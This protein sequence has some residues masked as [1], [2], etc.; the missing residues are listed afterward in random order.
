MFYTYIEVDGRMDGTFTVWR[1]CKDSG[2]IT[3]SSTS[4]DLFHLKKHEVGD[5]FKFSLDKIKSSINS[6]VYEAW[7]E[8]H[9]FLLHFFSCTL[10]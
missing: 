3:V 4:Q 5:T 6:S 8:K 2:V 9:Y 10:G 1:E 7:I